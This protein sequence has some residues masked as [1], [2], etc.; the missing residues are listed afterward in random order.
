MKGVDVADAAAYAALDAAGV[1][2]EAWTSV[3][4][5]DWPEAWERA[6]EA[7]FAAA[8]AAAFAAPRPP[9]V[10][11]PVRVIETRG[12][13]VVTAPVRGAR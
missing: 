5:L 1:P 13:P 3:P 11:T 6:V 8:I 2:R 4:T 7:A 10:V 12:G 9:P